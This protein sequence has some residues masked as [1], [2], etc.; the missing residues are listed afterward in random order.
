MIET[1]KAVPLTP[2][3]PGSLLRQYRSTSRLAGDGESII[4]Y[5]NPR[6]VT[7]KTRLLMLNDPL[8][9]FG[10]AIHMGAIT[11]L[12][13]TVESRDPEIKAF[14]Q[15]MLERIYDD[16]ALGAAMAIP[17]G[18]QV[19]EKVWAVKDLLV[20]VETRKDGE[21]STV[22]KNFPG[23]WII[24]ETKSIDHDSIKLLIDPEKDAWGGVEQNLEGRLASQG[25]GKI[26]TEHVVLWS[27]RK[28]RVNGK[29]TGWSIL[30]PVYE[31]WWFGV[32]HELHTNRYFE[33]KGDPSVVGRHPEGVFGPDGQPID[34]GAWILEQATTLRN[35]GAV[36]LSSKRDEKSGEY[37]A[38]LSYLQDDKRGDMFDKRMEKLEVRKLRALLV[39]DRVM[40]AGAGGLGTA[41]ADLQADV[42]AGFLQGNVRNWL[43]T[44]INPQ[45]VDPTVLYNFGEERLRQSRTKVVAGETSTAMKDLL[46]EVIKIVLQADAM[47]ADGRP[48]QLLERLDIEGAVRAAGLPMRPMSETKALQAARATAQKEAAELNSM[49]DPDPKLDEKAADAAQLS[50]RERGVKGPAGERSQ[51][52]E[53]KLSRTELAASLAL[54]ATKG[55][56]E[57]LRRVGQE[58]ERLATEL[59]NQPPP[60]TPIVIENHNHIT[61]PPAPD[62]VVNQGDVN[63]QPADVKIQ[64]GDVHV[65]ANLEIKPAE[66]KTVV[67]TGPDGK[68]STATITPEGGK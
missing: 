64:A 32:A 40:A 20:D 44:V 14:I 58:V 6:R 38:D 59:A 51:E 55:T 60:P 46:K 28:A 48:T 53:E 26:G 45:I 56:E 43:G 12:Q 30:D 17:L 65:A 5:F 35:G 41:D 31:P 33:R 63:V 18:W 23:A 2:P 22:E 68:E 37:L 52:D 21:I 36:A 13:W 42:L 61:Q 3:P 39:T 54:E 11:N 19:V 49:G 47:I 67:I 27:H 15:A 7:H 16:L 10:T 34:G 62:V 24:D 57:G 4:G 29:L 9:A 25:D 66:K 50:F 1:T 8:I